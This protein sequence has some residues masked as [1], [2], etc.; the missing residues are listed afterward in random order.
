M[1]SPLREGP[2]PQGDRRERRVIPAGPQRPLGGAT[3]ASAEAEGEKF[4]AAMNAPTIEALRAKAGDGAAGRPGHAAALVQPDR[5]RLRAAGAGVGDLHRGPAAQGAAARRL[6]RRRSRAS[7]TLKPQKPTAESFKA[8]LAKRFGASA[9]AIAQGL[10]PAPPTPRRSKPPPRWRATA[11]SATAR[12]S[13]SRCTAPPAAHQVYRYLF[14]RDIPI[15]PGRVQNGTPVTAKDIGARH[16]GEIEYV[17]GMLDTIKNVTWAPE[18]R[19]LSNAMMD[20]GAASRR[21][22]RRRRP[23]SRRGRRSTRPA[24]R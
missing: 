18:D 14:D 6:E 9:D 21:P 10:S 22:A 13:G 19:A 20:T 12:G 5:R 3:L 15:E 16:A 2:V 11:S 8:E 1:A 17:F 4:A 24:A 7:V 23:A